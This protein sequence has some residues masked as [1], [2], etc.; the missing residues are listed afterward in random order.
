MEN[1]LKIQRQAHLVSAAF[2]IPSPILV[3]RRNIADFP[4]R[5][6]KVP[7][8]TGAS[9]AP[10]CDQ[11]RFSRPRSKAISDYRVS[12]GINHFDRILPHAL[13]PTL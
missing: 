1:E 8:E 5:A 10:Y 12:K 9:G 13:R 4:A 7:Q 6:F 2:K 11:V 3:L